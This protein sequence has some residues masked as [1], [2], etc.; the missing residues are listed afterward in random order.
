M[1]D[2][3]PRFAMDQGVKKVACKYGRSIEFLDCFFF[4]LG[5]VLYNSLQGVWVMYLC[6]WVWENAESV[7]LVFPLYYWRTSLCS[8]CI[9]CIKESS[10]V[11]QS[12]ERF[13]WKRWD[14][15]HKVSLCW[16]SRRKIA[17]ELGG[18]PTSISLGV[19][20]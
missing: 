6:W 1:L 12:R 10:G 16:C 3:W 20:C 4:Y 17:I 11:E 9:L 14:L 13:L 18:S 7:S 5:R 8:S 15:G 2:I 19:R